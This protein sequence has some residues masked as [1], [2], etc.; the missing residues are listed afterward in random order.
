[1]KVAW[2]LKGAGITGFSASEDELK[3]LHDVFSTTVQPG[4]QKASYIVQFLWRDLTSGF[5]L[6][7]PY[8]PVGSSM[9]SSV[10]QEFLMLTLKALT[11]YDFKVSIMLCDGASSNLTL[12]KLLSGHPKAQLPTRPDAETLRGRYFVDASY[13]NPEDP[14]GNPI[15]LMI[16]PSHQVITFTVTLPITGIFHAQACMHIHWPGCQVTWHTTIATD[17]PTISR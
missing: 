16:C 1:M 8:F 9:Q 7:G 5:D 4:A 15:F 11:S 13:T 14:L 17:F 3:V 6:V 12:L 10:L 2:N